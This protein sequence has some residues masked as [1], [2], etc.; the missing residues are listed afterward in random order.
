MKTSTKTKT[1]TISKVSNATKI[2]TKASLI[3]AVP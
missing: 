3:T 1:L 2:A